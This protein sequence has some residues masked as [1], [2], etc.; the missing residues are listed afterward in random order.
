MPLHRP[1]C[2][3]APAAARAFGARAGFALLAAL[4]ASAASALA[5]TPVAITTAASAA[6]AAPASAPGSTEI[7][8]TVDRVILPLMR[9][10]RIPGMAVGVVD[11]GRSYV[12]NYGVASAA[13]GAAVT[14]ATL[15][16]VGSVTKC[17][18]AAL[19][20]WAVARQR[21]RLEAPVQRYVPQLRGSAFG[22]VSVLE[23]GTHT[24]G[25]VP[26]QVPDT[27]HDRAQLLAYLRAWK[28]ACPPGSCRSYSNIATGMLGIAAARSLGMP[29]EQ[30]MQQRLFPA[31]GLHHSWL[32]V[33][34]GERADYA[35]GTTQDGQPIRMRRGEL[36]DESYG[37]R[38]TAG[39]LLRYLR[40]NLDPRGLPPELRQALDITRTRYVQAGPLTQ[41]LVW[42]QVP[43]PAP[44]PTLLAANSMRMILGTVP[45]TPIEPPAPPAAGAWINKTGATNGFS[46]YVAMVPRLGLGLVLLANRN[47]PID[48][49][50]RAARDIVQALAAAGEPR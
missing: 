26:L 24:P 38:T 28:P 34:P 14:D 8:A 48:A 46:A 1:P 15:F 36:A 10:Q 31:L 23:L 27:V 35:L 19:A 42:E 22:R 37:L 30:A 11:H 17:F 2:H 45:A 13:T 32:R 4:A 3:G 33:P 47:I 21:L 44:L 18:T 39:D 7:T 16:E 25:G 49:Q 20:G 40:L 29:F 6:P 41:D 9:E 50:V 5:A 43:Y 12:L